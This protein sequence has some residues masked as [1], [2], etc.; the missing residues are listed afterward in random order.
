MAWR[1]WTSA[2]DPGRSARPAT[3]SLAIT[4]SA[5][6][7][8]ARGED[9]G[10]RAR[11]PVERRVRADCHRPGEPV[12]GD[13]SEDTLEHDAHLGPREVLSHAAV[14]PMSEREMRR[15]PTI[16]VERGRLRETGRIQVRRAEDKADPVAFLDGDAVNLQ[17]LGRPAAQDRN[18]TRLNS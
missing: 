1:Y 7:R 8:S 4:R 14:N 11:P 6:S 3:G 15:C 17:V 9:D 16:Q 18:S 12:V 5:G 10:H 13:A 2:A